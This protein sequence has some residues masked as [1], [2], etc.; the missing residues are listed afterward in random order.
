MLDIQF[1]VDKSEAEWCRGERSMVTEVK[2]VRCKQGSIHLHLRTQKER[3]ERLIRTHDSKCSKKNDT[4]A[5][6][7]LA[8]ARIL[9][10]SVTA[11]SF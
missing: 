6:F 1:T 8:N 4:L 11:L 5:G 7:I 3:D 10:N 9:M 2:L